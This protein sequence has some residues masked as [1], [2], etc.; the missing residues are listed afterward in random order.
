MNKNNSRFGSGRPK[1]SLAK[2][3]VDNWSFPRTTNQ[4]ASSNRL[5]KTARFSSSQDQVSFRELLNT[6]LATGSTAELLNSSGG[7]G[8]GSTNKMIA[9][10]DPDGND[11]T[12]EVGNQAK[13]FATLYKASKAAYDANQA[14]VKD[15]HVVIMQPGVYT[16]DAIS[17]ESAKHGTT[18][19][20]E[21]A[22]VWPGV[23]VYMMLGAKIVGT[24]TNA[25]QAVKF[26]QTDTSFVTAEMTSK[27]LNENH[28]KLVG[29]GEF[30]WL[31]S[32][33]MQTGFTNRT[34]IYIE[35]DYWYAAITLMNYSHTVSS[36]IRIKKC[37]AN[38]NGMF[39][40]YTTL[41][42]A[43]SVYNVHIGELIVNDTFLNNP[44]QCERFGDD[45][46]IELVIDDAVILDGLPILN[47]G[48]G[49]FFH[50]KHCD[51]RS[52]AKVRLNLQNTNAGVRTGN[53]VGEYCT[54]LTRDYVIFG[55]GDFE[56]LYISVAAGS[57][58]PR[59]GQDVPGG[60]VEGYFAGNINSDEGYPIVRL[61]HPGLSDVFTGA[62]DYKFV[63]TD[64]NQDATNYFVSFPVFQ[65]ENPGANNYDLTYNA[66]KKENDVWT[67]Q[68][69][70]FNQNHGFGHVQFVPGLFRCSKFTYRVPFGSLS[71]TEVMTFDNSA[72]TNYFHCF[73]DLTAMT[74][75]YN[76]STNFTQA[77]TNGLLTF[78]T[79]LVIQ[80]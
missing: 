68:V 11:L 67:L 6:A 20:T 63:V 43:G 40:A 41:F 32:G 29:N 30:T 49:S 55:E 45:S 16:I 36:V 62:A 66:P 38:Q 47:T 34:E 15:D 65:I 74:W 42:S 21:D 79:Q 7:G 28:Y 52:F 39:N 26:L 77:N 19:T 46:H 9:W 69:T 72:T 23:D 31:A 80:R 48:N 56:G 51:G 25:A 50:I 71:T 61:R 5:R 18:V 70:G 44:F 3:E 57:Y 8:G 76:S 59:T 78:G 58:F 4:N 14:A 17:D 75:D 73:F 22:L 27:G 2:R 54:Y 64:Y 10:V 60:R 53:V 24:E 12:A 33:G 1:I 37:V 13:P 35:L